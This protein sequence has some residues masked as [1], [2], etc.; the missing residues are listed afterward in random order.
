MLPKY[1]YN[2]ETGITTCIL[3]DGVN[4]IIGKAKCH[5]DDMDFGN[6]LVGETIATIRAEIKYFKL[7]IRTELRPKLNILKE[8][9]STYNSSEKYDLKSLE[10]KQ[11]Y[12]KMKRC[13]DSITLLHQMIAERKLELTAYITSKDIF[14][15]TLRKSQEGQNI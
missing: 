9:Y 6:H 7:V 10:A 11:V 4:T 15:K 2:P 14:Y 3:N 5:P 1:S 13:E 12:K 8:I